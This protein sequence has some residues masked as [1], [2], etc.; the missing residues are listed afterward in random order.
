MCACKQG[1]SCRACKH[2]VNMSSY[3]LVLLK[4]PMSSNTHSSHRAIHRK[5][6]NP[7]ISEVCATT[8][9]RVEASADPY[10]KTN[11]SNMGSPPIPYLSHPRVNTRLM[12]NMREN[13]HLCAYPFHKIMS[14]CPPYGGMASYIS[15]MKMVA[16]R[17]NKNVCC[18]INEY[19]YSNSCIQISLGWPNNQSICVT[20]SLLIHL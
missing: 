6:L 9:P 13:V 14:W 15:S 12:D 19:Q 1:K 4:S 10:A 8:P 5:N 16:H 18:H 11:R 2:W 20:S 3:W 7:C 17:N